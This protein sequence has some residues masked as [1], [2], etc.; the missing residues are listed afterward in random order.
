MPLHSTPAAS[1]STYWNT[2][3]HLKPTQ[4]CGHLRHKLW[5]STPDTRPPPPLR[6]R[7]N[8]WRAGAA[9]PP[10]LLSPTRLRLLNEEHDLDAIGWDAP[11]IAKLWRYNLHYFDDLAADGAASRAAWQAALIDRWIAENPPA[12]GS[13]WEPYPCS[14]RI[15]NWIKWI[16]SGQQP[17]AA[18]QASLAVQARWLAA[19][20]EWR[21]LGNHLLANAK[22]LAFAGVFFGGREGDTWL[23]S[24]LAIYRRELAEQ[25][26]DDGGHFERSPMY[27]AIILTDLLDLINLAGAYQG[28]IAEADVAAWRDLIQRMRTWAAAMAHPDG[29]ISFFNDAAFG[30]AP[31]AAAL[32]AY[33]ARLGLGGIAQPGDGVTRL[34]SSGYVRLQ[35]PGAVVLIDVASVG[36]DYL[37]GHAHADTLSFEMSVGGGRLLVNTGT[38]T[39][40]DGPLRR[41]QRSTAAHN[42]VQ[43]D[44]EDSSEMWGAFRVARRAYPLD[45]TI[46]ETA[47]EMRVSAAH[48]GYRRL[49][50]GVTHRRAWTLS[51]GRLTIADRIEGECR[52]AVARLHVHPEATVDIAGNTA[53]LKLGKICANVSVEQATLSCVPANWHPE[54]GVSIANHVLEACLDG[55]ACTT[56]ITWRR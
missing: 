8:S 36:P 44:G 37:P 12:T 32:D 55:G 49:S 52:Q 4:F 30:I 13:G 6:A 47:G 1:V 5:H 35:S 11:A 24:A 56:T 17:G 7:A 15:V 21:L 22:G 39:Y 43:I 42:T 20:V 41:A 2:L 48:D 10:S 45:V 23:R 40:A 46:V 38:S 27:H 50:P 16:L 29:E 28:V 9:Y 54:F 34:P 31:N 33:V 14:L 53:A 18:M 26:L 51:S 19:H 3:R 25:I